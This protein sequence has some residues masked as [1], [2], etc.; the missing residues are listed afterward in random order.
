MPLLYRAHVVFVV[1]VVWLSPLRPA[2]CVRDEKQRI[3]FASTLAKCSGRKQHVLRAVLFCPAFLKHSTSVRFTRCVSITTHRSHTARKS[4]THSTISMYSERSGVRER[5]A[6]F[7]NLA[8]NLVPMMVGE[9]IK[10]GMGEKEFE[11]L[12]R[13]CYKISVR[14]TP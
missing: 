7:W 9:C 3:L 11:G 1:V 2:W 4:K 12:D 5:E 8:A 13:V 14:F 6:L 10:D